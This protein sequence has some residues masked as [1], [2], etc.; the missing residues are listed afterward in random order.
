MQPHGFL[1]QVRI[2]L[3]YSLDDHQMLF[4]SIGESVFKCNSLEANPTD[5]VEDDGESAASGINP[6][7]LILLIGAPLVAIIIYFIRR[8]ANSS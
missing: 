1:C 5:V 3:L 2:P 7:L 6:I 4:M 8:R